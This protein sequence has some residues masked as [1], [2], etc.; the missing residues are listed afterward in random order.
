MSWA[1]EQE[2]NRLRQIMQ[3]ARES[4]HALMRYADRIPISASPRASSR[5][6][7]STRAQYSPNEHPSNTNWEGRQEDAFSDP[8][9]GRPSGVGHM[10]GDPDYAGDITERQRAR[11]TERR[12]IRDLADDVQRAASGVD[13]IIGFMGREG[14]AELR[15]TRPLRAPQNNSERSGATNTL[16]TEGFSGARGLSNSAALPPAFIV[17]AHPL[18]EPRYDSRAEAFDVSYPS[19]AA[20]LS[21]SGHLSSGSSFSGSLSTSSRPSRSQ[22]LEPTGTSSS[23]NSQSEVHSRALRFQ[24]YHRRRLAPVQLRTGFTRD[25]SH[26]GPPP[27]SGFFRAGRVENV[28]DRPFHQIFAAHRHANR[29]YIVGS[30]KRRSYSA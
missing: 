6:R 12:R 26:P 11:L 4:A 25:N 10:T 2:I 18:R 21:M 22:Y 15:E 27:R 5:P 19:D 13:R 24:Q 3:E 14:R 20:G 1:L 29:D 23:D 8:R 30:Q 7:L 28:E 9:M 17:G 16:P